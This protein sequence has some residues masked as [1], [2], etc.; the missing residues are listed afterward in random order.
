MASVLIA[1]GGNVG[2]V[3]TTFKKAIAHIC[4]MAQATVI[5]R[6]SDYATPPWGDENQDPFV[7]ACV[8]IETG[9]DPHALLFVMQ[10]VEQKFG[11]TRDQDRR[12]G[13]RTLDL[14][15]IAYDDV[16]M[17]KP[18]L[19]L[20]HPHLFERAFVLVPLAEIAPERVISG[21]RVRHAL[22]SVSTQGIEQLP[23]TG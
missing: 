22:A 18:D 20:P 10:K 7:N 11:R 9:L 3:R 16:S 12:W 14:D 21:I 5:A 8:E 13:P 2:D 15:M 17:N 6:S 23:D 4:G 1:L 19:T